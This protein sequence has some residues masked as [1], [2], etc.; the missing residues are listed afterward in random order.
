LAKELS[1]QNFH[2][3]YIR[4]PY[5]NIERYGVDITDYKFWK[6]S[7]K[8]IKT[9][10]QQ[11][12]KK[13]LIAQ[14]SLNILNFTNLLIDNQRE[15]YSLICSKLSTERIQNNYFFH[16]N[17]TKDSVGY[18]IGKHHDDMSNIFTILFYVPETDVNKDCFGINLC[19][20]KIQ[21]LPNRMIIFAPSMP[22]DPRPTTW[23]EVKKLPSSMIGTRN[24]F[25]MFFYRNSI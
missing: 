2:D 15:F 17:M 3:N 24:S 10:I 12:T 20:E 11:N 16:V 22:K 13:A 19:Q 18:E 6:D 1:D 8:S 9:T 23:H 5:G 7:G 25:Q 21:F 14:N 4:A